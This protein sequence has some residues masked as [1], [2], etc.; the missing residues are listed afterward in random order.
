[1]YRSRRQAGPPG[2]FVALVATALVFGGF[3]LLIGVQDFFRAGGALRPTITAQARASEVALRATN[4]QSAIFTAMPTNTPQPTCEDYR[5]RIGAGSVNVRRQPSMQAAI[6][7]TISEGTVVCVLEQ[8][9][10]WFLIDRDPRTRRID[11]GYV[12][13][14]LLQPVNPT[15]TPTHTFQPAPTITLTPSHTPTHTPT[16]TSTSTPTPSP[17]RTPAAP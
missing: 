11:E 3:R 12:F 15:P 14:T 8:Q 1:M 6:L 13:Q 7:Q 4:T 10:E 5:V 9:G 16:A 17:T 2:W